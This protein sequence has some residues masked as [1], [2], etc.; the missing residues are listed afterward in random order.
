MALS[1]TEA[2]YMVV[3]EA[4]KE[5][6]WMKDFI[7]EPR[8]R[9]E[10]FGLHF[11]NKSTI[12][13]ARNVTYHSKTKHIQR[14]YHWLRERIEENDFSLV[15]IHTDEN[16]SDMLTKVLSEEKLNACRQRV[17]LTKYPFR[18]EGGVC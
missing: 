8:I 4:D 5:I 10:E 1:T 15:K 12:H 9:Q 2:E 13:L 7:S 11:D 16:G 3:V 14:I 6:I 17:G 18:S